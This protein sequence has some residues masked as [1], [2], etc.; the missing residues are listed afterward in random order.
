MT[1]YH[2]HDDTILLQINGVD[3]ELDLR[4]YYT[5]TPYQKAPVPRG[6]AFAL[7]PDEPAHVEIIDATIQRDEAWYTVPSWLLEIIAHDCRMEETLLEKH[8][9]T[10]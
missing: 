8:S 10:D 4:V 7:E 9:S 2:I 6:E 1:L 5:Y 3:H